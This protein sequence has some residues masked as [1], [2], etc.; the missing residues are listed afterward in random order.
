MVKEQYN[1]HQDKFY[2]TAHLGENQQFKYSSE[3]EIDDKI[4]SLQKAIAG[5]RGQLEDFRAEQREDN[6][7]LKRLLREVRWISRESV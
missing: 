7:E 3:T 2:F 1:S 5:L 6:A 4:E